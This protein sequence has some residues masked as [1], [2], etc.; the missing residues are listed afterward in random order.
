MRMTGNTFTPRRIGWVCAGVLLAG[1]LGGCDQEEKQSAIT[2]V[3]LGDGYHLVD[4]H[5]MAV[6]ASCGGSGVFGIH[7]SVKAQGTPA[8]SASSANLK[9]DVRGNGAVHDGDQ[10]LLL[11][12][13][14][15]WVLTTTIDDL[16]EG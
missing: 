13:P 6:F 3:Y 10:M 1:L 15:G 7:L 2:A 12:T 11:K 8:P 14:P 9:W 4:G 5:P 16:M